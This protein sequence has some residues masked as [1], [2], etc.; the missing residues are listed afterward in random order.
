MVR[1]GDARILGRFVRSVQPRYDLHNHINDVIS[2]ALSLEFHV[3]GYKRTKP[4]R[5]GVATTPDKGTVYVGDGCMGASET[6]SVNPE[7]FYLG[8]FP[9]DEFVCPLQ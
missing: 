5:D 4:M 6:T 1:Q 8:Y 7:L 2:P 3:H 9:C